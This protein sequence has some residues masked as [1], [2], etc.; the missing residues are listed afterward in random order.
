M[1][2]TRT[3]GSQQRW[4]LRIFLGTGTG[5]ESVPVPFLSVPVPVLCPFPFPFLGG[6]ETGN[7]NFERA[8][9]HQELIIF[10]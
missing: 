10:S 1:V 5:T 8:L 3:T 4:A 7:L 6:T 9:L 2:A